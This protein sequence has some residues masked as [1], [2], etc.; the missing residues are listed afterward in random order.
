MLFI[1]HPQHSPEAT[2]KHMML[3]VCLAMGSILLLLSKRDDFKTPDDNLDWNLIMS[4]GFYSASGVILVIFH[5][6]RL[7]IH[8]GTTTA[9]QGSWYLTI[10]GY[11]FASGTVGTILALFIY[12]KYR[13]WKHKQGSGKRKDFV[14]DSKE[15]D[16]SIELLTL[17]IQQSEENS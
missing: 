1:A 2:A 15:S 3:G 6:R 4:G 7:P 8:M 11:V 17:D 13:K 14:T 5:E 12:D 9:C 16:G 10:F